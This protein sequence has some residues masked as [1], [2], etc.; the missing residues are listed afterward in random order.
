MIFREEKCQNNQFAQTRAMT[1]E[2]N[3]TAALFA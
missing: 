2:S 1:L 3:I